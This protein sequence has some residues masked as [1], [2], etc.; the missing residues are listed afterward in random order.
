LELENKEFWVKDKQRRPYKT[1]FKV[2][3]NKPVQTN[4]GK[5]ITFWKN[6]NLDLTKIPP[7]QP[8]IDMILVDE[9]G[10]WRAIELKT[11]KMTQK[12]TKKGT[13]KELS[14]P[15][16]VGF[17]QT[18][19]Y[20][21]FGIDEVAL[22]QCFDGNSMIDNEIY[23]YNDAMGK[24][25]E[26]L[27]Q[28]VD[29]TYFKILNEGKKPRIQTSVY[30]KNEEREWREWK[31]G[32]GIYQQETGIYDWKCHS[33]NPFLIP[34]QTREGKFSFNQEIVTRVKAVREFLE[35][36]KTE[37]WDKKKN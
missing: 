23:D 21:S 12:K 22:W 26:P 31:D 10:I 17:G 1:R 34:F 2:Y 13:R 32:V 25:R 20:L 19:A 30:Y 35:S 29:L 15:Y 3:L 14:S 16:Y 27:R 24:I 18:F 5:F 9:L 28:F 33:S 11:I 8:E 6:K 37:V 4:R 36:E 7:S